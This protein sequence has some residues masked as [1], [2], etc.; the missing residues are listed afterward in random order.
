MASAAPIFSQALF[1]KNL[2]RFW[3]VFASY[4]VIV[5]LIGFNLTYNRRLAPEVFTPLTPQLF[6]DSVY[7]ISGGLAL[8][9]ALFSIVSATAVFSYLFNTSAAG[10]MNA[11][12]YT[13]RTMYFSNYLS[14]LFMIILPL[15]VFFL[16]LTGIGI[17][18]NCLD[19]TALLGWLFIF[20]SLSLLLFSLAVFMAMLTG[21]IFAHIAFF[22]IANI[23]IFGLMM[24]IDAFLSQYL[25]GFTSLFAHSNLYIEALLTPIVYT[26]GLSSTYTPVNWWVWIAYLLAGMVFIGAA[27]QMYKERKM[28][29]AGDI[30]TISGL[31][32]IFKYG[33]TICT[34]LTL[35]EIILN[36][37]INPS[38]GLLVSWLVFI[39][40]GMLGYYVAEALLRKSFKVLDSY[41]GFV[42]YALIMSLVILSAWYDWYGYATRIPDVNQVEAVAFSSNYAYYH[43]NTLQADRGPVYFDSI[44][45]LPESL[46]LTYGT[47]ISPEKDPRSNEYLYPAMANLTP[48]ETRLL[49]S[50]SPG[51]FSQAD[52]KDQI[53]ALHQ[54]MIDNIGVL[55]EKYRTTMFIDDNN[56]QYNIT[57][58]YRLKNG[59]IKNC[60]YPVHLA[61]NAPEAWETQMLDQMASIAGCDEERQKMIAALD[62]SANHVYRI[63]LDSV[64]SKEVILENE[65]AAK[66]PRRY[67][68][69]I[70]IHRP[71]REGLLTAL[72][73]DYRDMT[74]EQILNYPG[75]F[76]ASMEISVERPQLPVHNKYRDV[77]GYWYDIG[78]YYTH[79]LKFL[80]DKG[81]IDEDIYQ[82]ALRNAE[83]KR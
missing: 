26:A 40:A 25:Y 13:R 69:A 12:P 58:Q 42:V 27:L 35:G 74:D 56:R 18:H 61:T 19:F 32:P 37:F 53:A 62:M 9:V 75:K 50:A 10:M 79:T 44:P 23:I 60:R 4:I 3:P 20:A 8:I 6:M 48:E 82:Y 76:I 21:N 5:L 83:D 68:E 51:I 52:S 38:S 29:K 34:S 78:A 80:R 2:Q 31:E 71:D 45:N 11:L 30:I 70:E 47:P 67:N 59:N 22:G 73:W 16:T 81:Y 66:T 43:E 17:I 72:K 33:V 57:F 1:R 65:S 49:W 77:R 7:S 63:V 41:K 39:L 24:V 46:A 55:R 54:Y 15:L 36:G 28:E 64:V 14:G